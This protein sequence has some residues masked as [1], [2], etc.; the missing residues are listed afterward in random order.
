MLWYWRKPL[1][2]Q[3][4]LYFEKKVQ[5]GPFEAYKYILREDVYDRINETEDC[6]RGFFETELPSGVS[7]L[8]KCFY[9][10]EFFVFFSICLLLFVR[11]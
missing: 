10:E 11:N 9:G 1:C 7:D 4:P 5:K 8:S 2:R 3:V 6:Y